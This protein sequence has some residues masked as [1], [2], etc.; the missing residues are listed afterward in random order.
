MKNNFPFPPHN[1]ND[2]DNETKMLVNEW[3]IMLDENN[4]NKNYN[5]NENC[6]R[7]LKR[8]IGENYEFT[9]NYDNG[10]HRK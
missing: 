2:S 7:M 3:E 8:E 5:S 9:K 6:F 1:I 4:D 10:V